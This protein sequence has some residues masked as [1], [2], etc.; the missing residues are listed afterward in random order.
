[1]SSVIF[2]WGKHAHRKILS[3]EFFAPFKFF[4]EVPGKDILCD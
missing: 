1:M 4:D 2:L 3:F